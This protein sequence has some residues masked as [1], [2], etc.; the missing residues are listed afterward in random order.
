MKIRIHDDSLRCRLG[1]RELG[2]LV[3]TGFLVSTTRFPTGRVRFGLSLDPDL[4]T[5][6]VDCADGLVGIGLPLEAFT[7]W[8]RGSEESYGFSA[9]LGDGT[10]DILIEKDFPCDSR[11]DC[12]ASDDL[13][14]PESL[15]L[16]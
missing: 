15:N 4:E 8:A 12:P 13:F 2:E 9:S 5:A 1:R 11:P 6:L 3:A 16:E 14:G 7:R 10:L